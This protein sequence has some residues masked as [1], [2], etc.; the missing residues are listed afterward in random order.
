M[1]VT[2]VHDV[3]ALQAVLD[4][5]HIQIKALIKEMLWYRQHSMLCCLSI[6]ISWFYRLQA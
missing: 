4:N 3:K 2:L 6:F 1:L 5:A